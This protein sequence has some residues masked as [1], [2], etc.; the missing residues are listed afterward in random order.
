ML[1]WKSDRLGRKAHEALALAEESE[2]ASVTSKSLT[3]RLVF[4]TPLGRAALGV[5]TVFG[6]R[7]A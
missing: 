5:A 4:T 3:E 6:D 7:P 2:K 1:V